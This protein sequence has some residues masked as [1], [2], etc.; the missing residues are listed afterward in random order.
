MIPEKLRE[1]TTPGTRGLKIRA[2]RKRRGRRTD[3]H[4]CVGRCGQLQRLYVALD[5]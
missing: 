3:W 4:T 1:R 5:A 2:I